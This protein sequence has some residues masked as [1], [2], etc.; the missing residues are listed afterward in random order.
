MFRGPRAH[1][2]HLAALPRTYAGLQYNLYVLLLD[3]VHVYT[4]RFNLVVVLTRSHTPGHC[5]ALTYAVNHVR[6]PCTT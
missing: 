2:A 1:G 4:T 5:A 6:A 3:R